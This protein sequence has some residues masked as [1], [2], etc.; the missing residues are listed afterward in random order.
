MVMD[1]KELRLRLEARLASLSE[2]VA[3]ISGDLR[4]TVHQDWQERA[5]E[6]E[7][8]EVLERLDESGRAELLNIEAA[9]KRLE[10]GTYGHCTACGEGIPPKRLEALPFTTHCVSCA[11]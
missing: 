10:A 8:D 11:P 3:K 2:R 6:A 4:Q 9:L 1:T 7:N 5:I